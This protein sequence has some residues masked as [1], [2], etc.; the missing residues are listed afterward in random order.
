MNNENTSSGKPQHLGRDYLRAASEQIVVGTLPAGTRIFG[1]SIEAQDF[2]AEHGL[3]AVHLKAID[4]WYV[5]LPEDPIPVP[6][7]KGNDYPGNPWV[8]LGM[9]ALIVGL[10]I[11]GVGAWLLR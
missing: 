4:L 2:A 10:V 8:D 7:T 3:S 9:S 6:A 5:V 1:S 11:A